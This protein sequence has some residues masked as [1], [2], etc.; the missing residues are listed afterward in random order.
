MISG[1]AS[2]LFLGGGLSMGVYKFYL[3]AH[4]SGKKEKY[5][6]FNRLGHTIS[7]MTNV[8]NVKYSHEAAGDTT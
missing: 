1:F 7:I 3:G 6:L 4:E 2:G 8:F 5:P